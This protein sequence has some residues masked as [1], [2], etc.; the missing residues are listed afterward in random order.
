[1]RY[2]LLLLLTFCSFIGF[3]QNSKFEKFI[4]WKGGGQFRP[5][6]LKTFSNKPKTL[7]CVTLVKAD[8]LRAYV[9]TQVAAF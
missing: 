3:A 5:I 7:T 6:A 2:L 9:L 1:M 8:S 4:G